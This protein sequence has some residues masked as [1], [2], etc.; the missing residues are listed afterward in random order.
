MKRAALAAVALALLSCRTAEVPPVPAAATSTPTA[1]MSSASDL[2]LAAMTSGTAASTSACPPPD[3]ETREHCVWLSPGP[4]VTGIAL[5][6]QMKAAGFPGEVEGEKVY[7]YWTPAKLEA[8]FGKKPTYMKTGGS[9]GGMVCLV[10]MP[11]GAKPAEKVRR[12]VGGWAIDD[13]VCEM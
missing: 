8:F 13:P 1:V 3:A 4:G 5:A 9:S 2:S 10:V 7:A 6:Q 12:F 11:K